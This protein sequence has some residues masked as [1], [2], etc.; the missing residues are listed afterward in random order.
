MHLPTPTAPPLGAAL[1]GQPIWH[2]RY[3]GWAFITVAFLILAA[4]L[5]LVSIQLAGVTAAIVVTVAVIRHLALALDSER[6]I[7]TNRDESRHQL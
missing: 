6:I 2:L 3:V 1:H 4:S 7:G 5:S